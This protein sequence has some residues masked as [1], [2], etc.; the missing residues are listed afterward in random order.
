MSEDE[1][2]KFDIDREVDKAIDEME[3]KLEERKEP[4]L[5]KIQFAHDI[6]K[7][8]PKPG[9]MEV[10]VKPAIYAMDL[11]TDAH[12][13][14]TKASTVFPLLLDQVKRT[15][16]D[17]KDS[18]KSEKRKLDF[19]YLFIIILAAGLVGILLLANV[20]FKIF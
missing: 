14:F 8:P 3:K 18:F 20:I 13:F 9:Y 12:W 4:S 16:I 10:K 5:S 1:P 11:N 15:H 6:K 2:I 19:N 7:N 17:L